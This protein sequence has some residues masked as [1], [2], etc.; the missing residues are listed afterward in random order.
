MRR[1]ETVHTCK[2]LMTWA[3][4]GESVCLYRRTA[5]VPSLFSFANR[6]HYAALAIRVCIGIFVMDLES[7]VYWWLL[8][9][10]DL[11]TWNVWFLFVV[12]HDYLSRQTI[13]SVHF[14]SYVHMFGRRLKLRVNWMIFIEPNK[15]Q[16][17]NVYAPSIAFFLYYSLWRGQ[18]S[19]QHVW[20]YKFPK[21]SL[22]VDS[23]NVKWWNTY[24]FE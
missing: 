5:P 8:I 17:I 7:P 19:F 18:N 15:F 3:E 12:K 4:C 6:M 14:L 9:L 11:E 10:Y 20:L 21:R 24:A 2:S 1:N 13:W 22:S 23:E 16:P